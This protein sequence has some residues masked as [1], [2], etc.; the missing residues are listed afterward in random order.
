MAEEAG[1]INDQ[2]HDM[3]ASDENE[4]TTDTEGS[5]G[6]DEDASHLDSQDEE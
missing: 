2:V 3:W 5:L 6:D 4:D 1:E